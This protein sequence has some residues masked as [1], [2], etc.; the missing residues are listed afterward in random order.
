MP[1]FASVP[2][3]AALG[4]LVLTG[5]AGGLAQLCLSLAFKNAPAAVVSPL[6]Y[7]GLIWATGFDILIWNIIPDWPVFLG[8]FIIISANCYIIYR[9]HRKNKRISL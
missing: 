5:I 6:N 1:F 8:A 7:T 9:E 3:S 2:T 4:F